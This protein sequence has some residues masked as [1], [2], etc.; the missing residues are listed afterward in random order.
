LN[1]NNK[2]NCFCK[3]IYLYFDGNREKEKFVLLIKL[4]LR[5]NLIKEEK[6]KEEAKEEKAVSDMG[7]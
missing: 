2:N 1:Y 6:E 5:N 3:N 4:I 7:R